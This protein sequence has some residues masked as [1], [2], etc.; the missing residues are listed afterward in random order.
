MVQMQKLKMDPVINIERLCLSVVLQNL[1]INLRAGKTMI[2]LLLLTK[3]N[4]NM[5]LQWAH[6][7]LI[8]IMKVLSSDLYG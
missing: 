5:I 7:S 1:S 8:L 3:L 2:T 4:L 6:T